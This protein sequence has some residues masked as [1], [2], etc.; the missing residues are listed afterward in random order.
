VEIEMK[1]L[2]LA[3]G[4]G[5]RLRPISC[6]RPKT[7]FPILNK[8]LLESIFERLAKNDVKEVIMAVNRLTEFYIK[9][10][11]IQEYG[12]EIKYSIDPPKKPLGTAGPI[13]Y[14]EN[15]IGKS[16]S[17]LVLN[18]DIF[19]DIN[20]KEI[21]K[22]HKEKQALATIA[23]YKVKDPT[24][25]GSVEI[26]NNNQ[27]TQFIE[28][29]KKGMAPTNLINAGIYVLD[30]ALFQYIE[31]DKAVSMEREIFPIIV[32]QKKLYGFKMQGLWMDIGKPAGYLQANKI[33]LETYNKKIKNRKK[34]SAIKNP[35]SI[36]TD[37]KI[38]LKTIIGPYTVIGKNVSVGN[39][40]HIIESV[41]FPDVKIQDCT[42]IMGAII[43]EG[44]II[45]KNVRINKGCIIGDYA[46][47]R[48]NL[49][50]QEGVAVCPGKELT[51]NILKSKIIC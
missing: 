36:D 39:G 20:Y 46:I 30:P 43:G 17:F 25:Y 19:A 48:D 9:K 3:G 13:K 40:T 27:I 49:S 12:L 42:K 31:K 16:D 8:P 21:I 18:G 32:E 5:T 35:V 1:A 6:T 29:P 14:A 38:G 51:E 41:I 22:I 44:V 15:L 34:N 4:F 28:K 33:L 2:I 26:A 45:G 7:L 10:Q 47:I 11:R 23:L 50:I 37:V 24:R